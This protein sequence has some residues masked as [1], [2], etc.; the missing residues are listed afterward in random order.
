V[1]LIARPPV[2]IEQRL[3]AL[4][5]A[6]LRAKDEGGQWWRYRS[7]FGRARE[8]LAEKG[9]IARNERFPV[10]LDTYYEDN[11]KTLE[12]YSE[13]KYELWRGSAFKGPPGRRERLMPISTYNENL[14]A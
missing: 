8:T 14:V 13:F 12:P 3:A 2:T 9:F 11:H 5:A 10:F 7:A 1:E 4:D 6:L